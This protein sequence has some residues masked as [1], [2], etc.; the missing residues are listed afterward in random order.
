MADALLRRRRLHLHSRQLRVNAG[1]TWRAG[2]PDGHRGVS[3]IWIIEGS[4]PNEDQV[5]SCLSFAKERRSAIPTEPTVHSIAA[6]RGARKVA[7][8]SR[9][10]E[11]RRAK[12]SANGSAA[13]A[14]VLTVP[15]PTHAGNDWR[16]QAFPKNRTAEAPAS[17]CHRSLQGQ[18]RERASPTD[19]TFCANSTLAMPPNFS[20]NA[21]R[22]VA[23]VRLACLPVNLALDLRRDD[24][25]FIVDF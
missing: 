22:T 19:R 12:A 5:W 14:Q 6:V 2:Y 8:L 4:D 1:P 15:A 16:L 7:C 24:T 20:L 25:H 23:A 9:N 3:E 10:L 13:C 17:H 21:D 18:K 11:R